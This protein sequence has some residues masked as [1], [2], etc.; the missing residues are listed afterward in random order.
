[1]KKLNRPSVV[2]Y[3]IPGIF[4]LINITIKFAVLDYRDISHDEPFSIFHAQFD[5]KSLF[6]I[7][8]YENNP[9]LF[10]LLLH[11]WIKVFG[12]SPVSVRFLPMVFSVLTVPVLYKLGIRFYN[13]SVAVLVSV[14]FTFSNYHL[15]FSH[16]TRVYSL[17]GLLTSISFYAFFS[18]IANKQKKYNWIWVI[19]NVLLLYAHFFGAFIAVIQFLIVLILKELRVKYL[20][21]AFKLSLI[22]LFFYLPYLPIFYKRFTTSA[23]EGTWLVQP[24]FESLYNTLWKFSNAPVTTSVFLFILF[25]GLIYY[26]LRQNRLQL[27]L[28][29]KSV[30]FWFVFPLVLI[31]SVSFY[32][33]MYLD[34]YL[35]FF[36]FAWYFLIAIALNSIFT[37]NWQKAIMI[38]ILSVLMISTFVPYKN[39]YRIKDMVEEVKA[40]KTEV[41]AVIISPAYIDKTFTYYYNINFFEDWQNLQQ[42]LNNDHIYPVYSR[43]GLNPEKISEFDHIIHIDASFAMKDPAHDIQTFLEG[44]FVQ[45]NINETYHSFKIYY[46]NKK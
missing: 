24:N 39:T 1:M 2:Y 14:L 22:S 5:L 31:F 35:T 32:I 15:L 18:I 27:S 42:N 44:K 28:I 4:I 6:G 38:S 26:F 36:S 37:K 13:L 9:P 10:Y 17:F 29:T 20:A 41:T 34:R 12:I 19:T 45:K 43:L 46:Y 25:L 23:S 16:D 11:F 21:K 7:L 3:I 40:N 8:P 33:P 30:I